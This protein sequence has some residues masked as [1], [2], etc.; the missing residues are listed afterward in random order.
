MSDLR[1][2]GIPVNFDGEERSLLFSIN[3]IE[4][5]ETQFGKPVFEVLEDM[6]NASGSDR[7]KKIR[8]VTTILLN[9]QIECYNLTNKEHQEAIEEKYVGAFL[10]GGMDG[11]ADTMLLKILEAYSISIPKQTEEDPNAESGQRRN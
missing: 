2:V 10:T 11:T 6:A 3:A 5:L 1:P 4:E 9:A 7:V 8:K